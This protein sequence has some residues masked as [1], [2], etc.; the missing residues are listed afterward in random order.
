[1]AAFIVM[2]TSD[3]LLM[4]LTARRLTLI[5]VVFIV[6]TVALVIYWQRPS[7]PAYVTAPARLGD[8]E[9]AVLATGR[10]DAF[11]R[12]NVGAQV[13]GQVKSLKV[14]L[15]DQITKGQLV[16]DIDSLPQRNE[17]RT[18]EAALNI[19]K[20]DRQ[21]KQAQL[22]QAE[23]H[24][25][26]QRRML[27]DEASSRE[28]FE[29]AEEQLATTRAELLS[30]DAKLVQM[31]VDVEKKKVDLSYTRVLAPMDGIVIAVVTQQGQTVNSSQ[32]AP[33]IIKLARLD[34]MTI[35]AQI[36]EADITHIFAGQKAYF[37]IFSEPDRRYYA[38]L[39]TV[40]LAPES[41]MKDD[42]PGASN[43]SATD[44]TSKNASV[45]YNALLDVPNPENRLR[46]GM[47]SQVS[48]LREN[49]KNTLLVPIQA[50]QKTEGKKQQVRVLSNSGQ[51]EMREVKTGITDNVD[52]QILSGLKVGELVV[53]SQPSTKPAEDGIFL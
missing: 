2:K 8:I 31:Q 11:E 4:K 34:V 16:A 24:F 37:S 51:L 27:N 44:D 20:A 18:A 23:S 32:S 43:S 48:L 47:T 49:A 19:V 28:D 10:L 13:S 35:K 41:V 15:G 7:P 14:K 45:Y 39:R 50:V 40:E 12:V 9:N 22:K 25:K 6:S 46:I 1:M 3:T 33:T 53:L 21:A 26:R 5:A 52:I 42:A 36:S 17:L 29:K 30:L 38:T